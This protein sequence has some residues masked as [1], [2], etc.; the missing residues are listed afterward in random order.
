MLDFLSLNKLYDLLPDSLRAENNADIGHFDILKLENLLSDGKPKYTSYARRSYFKVSL[1][2]GDSIVH[3]ADKSITIKKYGL[4]FTNPIVPYKWEIL[5]NEQFG[6]VCVFTEDFFTNATPIKDYQVFKNPTNAVILLDLDN[7]E[8]F[9]GIFQK[10]ETELWSDYNHKYDYLRNLFME[11][12]HEAQKLQPETG[13]IVTSSNAGERLAMLFND[14][15]DRQFSI[16]DVN[17]TATLKSPSDF[18]QS[19]NVHV[20]HL[21]KALKNATGHTTSQLIKKRILKEAKVLLKTTSWSISQISH[22]LGFE[23]PNHFSLFFKENM[24]V[25]ARNFRNS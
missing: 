9:S 25:T 12:I 2:K 18:S 14:L 1:I 13:E 16:T 17:D 5:N 10:M 15:L 11:V 20:N 23:Q 22:C 3:Y 4:I 6:F 21:N 24:S 19:L 8:K 7:F